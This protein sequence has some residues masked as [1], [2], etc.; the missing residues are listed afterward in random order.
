MSC[1]AHIVWK[2]NTIVCLYPDQSFTILIM[3]L[4]VLTI[5]YAYNKLL[6]ICCLPS[7]L[8]FGDHV[9]DKTIQTMSIILTTDHVADLVSIVDHFVDHVDHRKTKLFRWLGC[10]CL[11]W[12][13]VG[14]MALTTNQTTNI[15]PW[16]LGSLFICEKLKFRKCTGL[17]FLTVKS[18]FKYT[19]MY[20]TQKCKIKQILY[21]FFYVLFKG[22]SKCRYPPIYVK[23]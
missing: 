19:W 1:R 2:L 14:V 13:L 6:T 12:C 18:Y 17:F 4:T 23:N 3:L 20:T 7:C 9:G 16:G 8:Y 15:A 11:V 22:F 5:G 10:R 21:N